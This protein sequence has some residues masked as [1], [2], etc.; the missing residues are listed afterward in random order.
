M[1][2]KTWPPGSRADLRG[3]QAGNLDTKHGSQSPPPP[4][5]ERGV[6]FAVRLVWVGGIDGTTTAPASW[7]YDIAEPEGTRIYSAGAN[8]GASPHK[9]KRPN[10]GKMAKA[11]F[12]LA[13]YNSTGRVILT[14]INEVPIYSIC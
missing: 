4:K 6:V 9:W 3:E 5:T 10:I 7:T 11:D 13:Y 14:W 1:A 8:P 12:G 2:K